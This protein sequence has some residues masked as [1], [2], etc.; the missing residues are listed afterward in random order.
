M[1]RQP[2]PKDEKAVVVT[3]TIDKETYEKMKEYCKV[4][5]LPVSRFIARTIKRFFEMK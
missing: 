2:K 3:I 5:Y 4:E 1:P